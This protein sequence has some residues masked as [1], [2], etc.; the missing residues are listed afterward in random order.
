[1]RTQEFVGR[2]LSAAGIPDCLTLSDDLENDFCVE[3]KRRLRRQPDDHH[4][5][6]LL[7]V[8]AIGFLLVT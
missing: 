6:S 8:T 7:A 4:F 1:M 5:W 2:L 3:E